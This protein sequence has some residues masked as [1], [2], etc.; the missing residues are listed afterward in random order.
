MSHPVVIFDSLVR[1]PDLLFI[2]IFL[3]EKKIYT[4]LIKIGMVNVEILPGI[5]FMSTESKHIGDISSY[6]IPDFSHKRETY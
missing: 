3:E 1:L 5:M 6:F 4:G 2:I